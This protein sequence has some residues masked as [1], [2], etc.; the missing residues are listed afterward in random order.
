MSDKVD[1]RDLAD[2]LGTIEFT[3]GGHSELSGSGAAAR[4]LNLIVGNN[5]GADAADFYL[6]HQPGSELARSVLRLLRPKSAIERCLEI[7]RSAPD[8]QEACDSVEL[9]RSIATPWVLEH[10]DELMSSHN[11]TTRMWAV[12]LLDDLWMTGELEV[13]NGWPYLLRAIRDPSPNVVEQAKGIA[14]M[15]DDEEKRPSEAE[16]L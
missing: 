15:W 11:E 1:W 6:S 3:D 8:S 2:A 13:E 9:L 12:S 4:A 5:I 10:F 7:F 14:E 16:G